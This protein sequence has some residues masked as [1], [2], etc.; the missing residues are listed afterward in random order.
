LS[1][2]SISASIP[3]KELR[4]LSKSVS[5]SVSEAVIILFLEIHPS[6]RL[7][8]KTLQK[9]EFL[10]ANSPKGYPEQRHVKHLGH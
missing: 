1:S 3:C 10:M 4:A 2:P 6:K 8:L 9:Q 5:Q 7:H